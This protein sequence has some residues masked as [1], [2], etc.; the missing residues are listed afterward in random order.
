MVDILVFRATLE[1]VNIL[2]AFLN[3]FLGTWKSV[4]RNSYPEQHFPFTPFFF[5]LVKG[6]SETDRGTS[7]IRTKDKTFWSTDIVDQINQHTS[8]LA[9]RFYVGSTV[10]SLH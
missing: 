5:F 10:I 6:L 9:G 3:I 2:F 8:L 1:D 7:F 4:C